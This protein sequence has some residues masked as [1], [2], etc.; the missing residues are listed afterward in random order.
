MKRIEDLLLVFTLSLKPSIWKCQVVVKEFGS[1]VHLD[2]FSPFNQSDH[3][4]VT[5]S[6]PLPSSLLRLLILAKSKCSTKRQLFMVGICN[7]TQVNLF[8]TKFSFFASALIQQHSNNNGTAFA[9]AKYILNS[10]SL[11]QTKVNYPS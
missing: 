10:L 6:L 9:H 5:L 4:F 3:C 11:Q 1:H 2:Y 7:C 8:E